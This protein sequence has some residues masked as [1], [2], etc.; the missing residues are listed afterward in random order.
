[1]G[2]VRAHIAHFSI[3]EYSQAGLAR[4]DQ[5]RSAFAAEVQENFFSHVIGK[6][7][8]RPGTQYINSTSG[9]NQARLIP[10][11]RA[12]DDVAVIEMTDGKMRVLVDDAFVTR[13]TALSTIQ[14]GDFSSATGW[15][16]SETD[17]ATG[18]I[19]SNVLTMTAL[20]R[21]STVYCEQAVSTTSAGTEHALNIHVTRGPVVFQ[22]GSTS[23]GSDYI[24]QTALDTGYHSLTFTPTGATYYPR[25][26]T[27][28]TRACE[29]NSIE[30][31][32]AGI[33]ELT[34]P[35]TSACLR[36]IRHDQSIDVM[37]LACASFS[38]R[39]IERRNNTTSWSIVEYQSNDGPFDGSIGD[40]V[41]LTPA[42]TY[43]NTTITADQS[44]FNANHVGALV[45]LYHEETNQTWLL[46]GEPEQTDVYVIRGVQELGDR[47]HTWTLFSYSTGTYNLF[48]GTATWTRSLTGP[49]G[50]F[51]E[52]S[53]GTGSATRTSSGS[54]TNSGNVNDS[55][56]VSYHRI[57][58]QDGDYT[59]GVLGVTIAYDGYSAFGVG[60]ITAVNS[61][62]EAE[63]EVLEDFANVNGTRSW[64]LGSWCPAR[65]WPSAVAFF[66]GRLWWGGRDKIWGSAS[67]A[68]Y[69]YDDL[70]EGDAASIQRAL[71]TGAQVAQVNWFLPLQRLIIG[72]TGSEVSARSSSFDEPLTPTNVTLKDASSLGS[73][74]VSP[75][76]IDSRGVFVHRSRRSV[77]SVMY[78]LDNND[79]TTDNLTE[80]NEDICGTGIV[81]LA[82]Q[83]EPETY[84]WALRADGQVAVLN[85]DWA[86]NK[87]V[88]GWFRYVAAGDGEVES[89]CVVPAEEQDIVYLA[90]KRTI[91]G[92]TVRY[93]EKLAQHSEV[94]GGAISK[95]ADCGLLTAGPTSSVT[96]AHL[97]NE[98]D[99]V[100][101]GTNAEG[102][103]VPLTGLSANAS[104]VVALDA[105]YTNVWVGMKYTSRYK[106]SRLVYGAQ[107]GTALLQRKRVDQLGLLVTNT[108]RD[109]VKFGPSFE[110]LRQMDLRKDGSVQ[111]ASTVYDVHDGVP[112]AFPGEWDTDSRVCIEVEAPY[113]C[114]LN[115]LVIGVETNEK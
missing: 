96:L 67:D 75:V 110:K 6:G 42:Q 86:E 25:F 43:G 81:E 47:K 37:F 100:G 5:E 71:A 13:P 28:R 114:T 50:D 48:N 102:D 4:V 70:E 60:R 46:A 44:V 69:T 95:S 55:N 27:R 113:P 66:D 17:G 61:A 11:L 58:F 112:F 36:T 79:Y 21:G 7:L 88:Q 41:K 109:A 83:R 56:L 40:R 52:W 85:Y 53:N 91:N 10:F 94:E 93:I 45:R 2:K 49:D 115:G 87:Q 24:P 15:T 8:A 64:T 101:W 84:V 104:G 99:L 34:A 57:G 14:N 97:A 9:N 51:T 18:T 111:D 98:T 68:Y 29:V 77:H 3:G 82:V 106:S 35:W 54:V 80:L 1:M 22:V 73:A 62:V 63:V 92:S 72:T 12:I 16:I 74:S 33:M 103:Q 76:K 38:P 108:H 20:A 89:V 23:G 19:A 78:S 59:S 90:V 26:S 65:Q 30:V 105:V 31:A 107:G 39:M 32:S